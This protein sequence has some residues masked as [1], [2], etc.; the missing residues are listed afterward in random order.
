MTVQELIDKLRSYPSEYKVVC[1]GMDEMGYC[2]IR[3]VQEKLLRREIAHF[4]D[5]VDP[6]ADEA[7]SIHAVFLDKL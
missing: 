3:A 5:Y 1:R 2:D 7:G 6:S 4:C